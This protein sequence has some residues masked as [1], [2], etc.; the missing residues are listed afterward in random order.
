MT[1][2]LHASDPHFGTDQPVVVAA[3][4]ELV[5]ALS[6]DLLVVSGDITQRARA[7]QFA[8]A[9][10][11]AQELSVPH[12]LSVPGNH[13]IPLFDLT[14]RV[15]APYSRYRTAFGGDLEPTFR[16]PDCLVMGVNT[17]R[18]YRHV[19]G[20]ISASQCERVAAL[21]REA[22]PDQLRLVVLHH[23]VA[24]PRLSELVNV[25]YGSGDAI[26]TWSAAGADL[27]LAG[28]I[29]LPF[30]LPLHETMP[31][32]SKPLWAINAGTAVSRR[33]R[34]DAGNS[35]NVIKTIVGEPRS[36]SLEQWTFDAAKTAFLCT[37]EMRLVVSD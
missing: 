24:I 17:T 16:A 8:A 30:V 4:R 26:R 22:D 23:P 25:A 32:A 31:F 34:H 20:E 11:F 2:I 6:P 21:L 10:A 5:D 7:E 12:S 19:D 18:P 1:T 36:C 9:Q 37:A 35:V 15:F 33:T 3:L 28:H 13:D 29:H 27:I 14:R